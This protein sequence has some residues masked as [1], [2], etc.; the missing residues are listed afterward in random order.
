MS[1]ELAKALTEPDLHWLIGL[2]NHNP[3]V[4]DEERLRSN[5]REILSWRRYPND[6][7]AHFTLFCALG[8]VPN[9]YENPELLDWIDARVVDYILT[10]RR[11]TEAMANFMLCDHILDHYPKDRAQ[12][13]SIVLLE[14]CRY[15][16]RLQEFLNW[17]HL[18]PDL[19]GESQREGLRTI[20][21][22]LVGSGDAKKEHLGKELLRILEPQAPGE[23]R[24]SPRA[25]PRRRLAKSQSPI[26]SANKARMN[27]RTP[28]L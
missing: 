9:F 15:V 10:C 28:K 4:V 6:F 22:S 1:P 17:V 13:L 24:R 27:P 8:D 25:R 5:T 14:S 19:I 11:D 23:Y 20:G 26:R 16:H 21:F 12:M 18:H 3:L 7:E 2:D